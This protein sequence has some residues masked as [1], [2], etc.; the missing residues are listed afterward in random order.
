MAV[1]LTDY[2]HL[3][4]DGQVEM[5][6]EADE[7][8]DLSAERWIGAGEV[9]PFCVECRVGADADGELR[10]LYRCPESGGIWLE[11]ICTGGV[12]FERVKKQLAEVLPLHVAVWWERDNEFSWS[13]C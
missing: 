3:P 12:E 11:H 4:G 5:Q 7:R 2:T 6:A 8:V 1:R 13:D 9:P 10:W